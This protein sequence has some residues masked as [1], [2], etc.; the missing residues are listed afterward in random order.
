MVDKAIYLICSA[1]KEPFK[2]VTKNIK[3]TDEHFICLVLRVMRTLS[4]F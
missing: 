1:V 3:A 2:A 4:A